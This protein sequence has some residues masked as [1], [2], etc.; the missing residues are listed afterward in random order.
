MR[1][2]L[3]REM[4]QKCRKMMRQKVN[5]HSKKFDLKLTKYKGCDKIIGRVRGQRD[6]LKVKDGK[7]DV[8]MGGS[9]WKQEEDPS[10]SVERG[11]LFVSGEVGSGMPSFKW[12]YRED[13]SLFVKRRTKRIS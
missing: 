2:I 7:S 13:R 3:D 9:L 4:S 10:E 11:L 12:A 1:A 6:D 5:L 8:R